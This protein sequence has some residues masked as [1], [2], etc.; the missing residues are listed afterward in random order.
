MFTGMSVQCGAYMVTAARIGEAAAPPRARPNLTR[1][2]N[3]RRPVRLAGSA[4]EGR[5][6]AAPVMAS[7]EATQQE[8]AKS[9][10]GWNSHT[11]A[12]L[13]SRRA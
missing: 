1:R 2:R 3:A 6:A 12:A 10:L 8:Q 9:G 7:P 13:V 11:H 4:V 5:H